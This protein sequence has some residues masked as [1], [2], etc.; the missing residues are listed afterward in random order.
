LKRCPECRRDHYDD[1]LYYCLDDGR[2]LVERPT[3]GGSWNQGETGTWLTVPDPGPTEILSPPLTTADPPPQSK[4]NHTFIGKWDPLL[5][6]IRH[7]GRFQR[8]IAKAE[9]LSAEFARGEAARPL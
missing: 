2:V 9:K 6:N 1:S 5:E 4:P 3:S 7:I 8:L